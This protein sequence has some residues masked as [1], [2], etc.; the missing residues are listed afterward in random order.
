[1]FDKEI[2]YINTQVDKMYDDLN[3]LNKQFNN[4]N[5][6]QC[7]AGCIYCCH[8]KVTVYE[9]EALRVV[10]YIK[11]N[12][13]Q[14]Q[15]K[16]LVQD[17]Q[18][19]VLKTVGL[20]KK[21]HYMLKIPCVFIKDGLCSIY[22]VRPSSCRNA[23]SLSKQSCVDL[24]EKNNQQAGAHMSLDLMNTNNQTIIKHMKQLLNEGYSVNVN[25]FLVSL[26]FALSD[27]NSIKSYFNGAGLVNLS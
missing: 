7:D 2:E 6:L 20:S 13:S 9:P 14:E 4:K 1:M 15:I 3:S 22:E 21:D 11:N 24:F 12:F 16:E 26:L 10:S 19:V 18:T 17:I 5:I 25:E 23:H 27:T 8:L